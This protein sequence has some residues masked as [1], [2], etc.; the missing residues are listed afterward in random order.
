MEQHSSGCIAAAISGATTSQ[1]NFVY[2]G[3]R[4]RIRNLEILPLGSANGDLLVAAHQAG[5]TAR[6]SW[7]SG[8]SRRRRWN[9]SMASFFRR[10][11]SAFALSVASA[12]LSCGPWLSSPCPFDSSASRKT[13]L[14]GYV[15]A[16]KSTTATPLCRHELHYYTMGIPISVL[17]PNAR[18]CKDGGHRDTGRQGPSHLLQAAESSIARCE[19]CPRAPGRAVVIGQP[20]QL[21]LHLQVMSNPRDVARG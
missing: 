19:R 11:A 16:S 7:R 21:L 10:R 5:S 13:W 6:C 14:N 3:R 20:P 8:S 1:M 15:T 17:K 2:S 12:P 18:S 4:R 9:A